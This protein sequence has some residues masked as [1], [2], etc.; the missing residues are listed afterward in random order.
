MNTAHMTNLAGSL[1]GDH[2]TTL[3]PTD[4]ALAAAALRI[5]A[6]LADAGM[7]DTLAA[8]RATSGM[9]ADVAKLRAELASAADTEAAVAFIMTARK[10]VN[11]EN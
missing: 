2:E 5:V 7:L 3:G 10:L 4:S 6:S 9:R 11:G 1:S 8:A